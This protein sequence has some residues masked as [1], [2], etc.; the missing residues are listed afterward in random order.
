SGTNQFGKTLE[1]HLILSQSD[2]TG[3]KTVQ[4]IYQVI[5]NDFLKELNRVQYQK[6]RVF[7]S[8]QFKN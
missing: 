7:P 5:V 4:E 8:S 1:E 2:Y 3:V 6:E